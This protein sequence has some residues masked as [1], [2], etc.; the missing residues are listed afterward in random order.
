MTGCPPA[1]NG[2]VL[3]GRRRLSGSLGFTPAVV[4]AVVALAGAVLAFFRVPPVSAGTIWAE[5]GSVF[6][7]EYLEQGPALLAPYDGYLHALPRL[8]VALVV[9]LF[10]LEAY[11]VAV[12]AVCSLV[13]GL[14][15]A[16]TYFCSSA[17]TSD[18]SARL[19]WASIPVLVAPGALE[20][21]GNTANLHWYMLW[22]MPW[23]L[24]RIPETLTQKLL[25]AFAALLAALSE[26][27]T[28]LFLPLVLWRPGDKRGW[29]ARAG[30][31]IGVA[32]QV[33]TLLTFPREREGMGQD[34]DLLSVIYGYFLNSSA[35]L[36]YGSST[37]IA[38][39]I[40]AFGAL[41]IIVSAIPFAL[42]AALIARRA[43]GTQRIAGL[44]WLLASVIIWTAAVVI[45]PAPYFDYAQF[46]TT[47]SW[48]DFFLSRYSTAPSM[49][50]LALVPLLIAAL[51][52]AENSP[53]GSF[54]TGNR[55]RG[56]LL[57]IF[58]V[59]QSVYFFPVDAARSSG[60][61]WAEGVRDARLVCAADPAPGS[62][63]IAQQPGGW[64]SVI[65]CEDLK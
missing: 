12:T 14:T 10:G 54:I 59:L 31:I 64:Q 1:G 33:T 47:G 3:T 5:D 15:A 42:V 52:P 16:L 23:V 17:L 6:L 51:V 45:N 48:S 13:V 36:A 63:H 25:L 8:V 20:T 50:L 18:M 65:R 61:D 53:A 2:V 11:A 37:V 21:M 7:E 35:A 26:I 29:W 43:D 32:C 46:G 38:N 30:F 40:Q 19:A 57:G 27:Q 28:A 58:V 55:F 41:P 22:L 49:F 60:P 34:W 24:L 56:I 4:P 62:V 39:H 9:P 44:T